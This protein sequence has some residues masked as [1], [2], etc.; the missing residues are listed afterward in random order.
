MRGSVGNE[1]RN[2]SLEVSRLASGASSEHG[3]RTKG[4]TKLM[5]DAQRRE[6]KVKSNFL[7]GDVP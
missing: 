7:M 1:G 3:V 6:D 4:V 5:G 2:K